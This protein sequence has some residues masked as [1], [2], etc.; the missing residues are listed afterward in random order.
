[1]VAYFTFSHTGQ[2]TSATG[3]VTN[4]LRG[5]DYFEAIPYKLTISS[6]PTGCSAITVTRSSVGTAGTDAGASTGT[7]SNGSTIY[8][9]DKLSV[10]ATE[11]EVYYNLSYSSSITVDGNETVTVTSSLKT[12]PL[13]ITVPT[14]CNNVQYAVKKLGD[15]A[16]GSYTTVSSSGKVDIEYG[17]S[18]RVAA[19]AS[20]GYKSNYPPSSPVEFTMGTGGYAFNPTITPL[21]CTIKVQ[22]P[23]GVT[24]AN[25]AIERGS[26]AIAQGLP[27]AGGGVISATTSY[28]GYK[29]DKFTVFEFTCSE[30]YYM[31]E[32]SYNYTIGDSGLGDGTVTIAPQ[33]RLYQYSVTIKKGTGIS[34]IYYRIGSSGSYSSTTLDASLTVDHGQIVYAYGG[35]TT[36]SSYIPGSNTYS[37]SYPYSATIKQDTTKT[38][39]ASTIAQPVLAREGNAYQTQFK[40]TN[41]NP[42][43]MT[44]YYGTS[45]G[46]TTYSATVGANGSTYINSSVSEGRDVYGKFYYSG[47]T[48]TS[49]NAS[50]WLE[51]IDY[52]T[53]STAYTTGSQVTISVAAKTANVN[54]IEVGYGASSTWS[55]TIKSNATTSDGWS[56]SFTTPSTSARYFHYRKKGYATKYNVFN[57]TMS[58]LTAPTLDYS[59]TTGTVKITN[60]SGITADVYHSLNSTYGSG[61]VIK[62]S[63]ASGGSYTHNNPTAG[64]TNYYY[65]KPNS[66]SC[67]FISDKASVNVAGLAFSASLYFYNSDKD[68]ERLIGSMVSSSNP[69]TT[70]NVGNYP[71]YPTTGNSLTIKYSPAT[72]NVSIHASPG[73]VIEVGRAG[74]RR[75]FWI[76][77]P[78]NPT[79]ISVTDGSTTK[80]IKVSGTTDG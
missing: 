22:L 21:T 59:Q 25:V 70:N 49:S 1:M 66:N 30:G 64:S 79:I 77:G 39:S 27:G 37:A 33:S 42:Y 5:N 65:L 18:V 15:S 68:D 9:G 36:G 34:T 60:N 69:S 58:K 16:W 50:L 14:N 74:G 78:G 61:T 40:V 71:H 47:T 11:S 51:S 67:R 41:N 19:N 55:T 43:A 80:Y 17:A 20:D 44:F 6:K 7:L 28:T 76:E 53:T 2:N 56:Q 48:A 45:S 35:V 4:S 72:A 54:N 73:M 3:T 23:A 46:A 52:S 12:Y 24:S 57:Y 38:L 13:T 62:S 29:G 26:I 75:D 8:H 32:S 31:V 63:L 10:S